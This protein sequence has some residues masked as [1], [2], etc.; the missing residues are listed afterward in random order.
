MIDMNTGL[1]SDTDEAINKFIIVTN[2]EEARKAMIVIHNDDTIAELGDISLP[3]SNIVA[4]ILDG[5]EL[6]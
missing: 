5:Y 6:L 1:K 4:P 3:Y 2:K